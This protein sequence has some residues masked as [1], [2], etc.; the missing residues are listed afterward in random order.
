[1]GAYGPGFYGHGFPVGGVVGPVGIPAAWTIDQFTG[2]PVPLVPAFN[3]SMPYFGGVNPYFP[4]S[5]LA[6]T[7]VNMNIS[8]QPTVPST[9]AYTMTDPRVMELLAPQMPLNRFP[10]FADPPQVVPVPNGAAVPDENMIP[11]GVEIPDAPPV[12]QPDQG[13][14]LLNEFEAVPLSDK[15]SNLADRINSLRYQSSGDTAFRKED[16]VSAEAAYRSAIEVAPNRRSPY[17]R[18]AFVQIARENFPSAVSYLK[19]ALQLSD[20]ATRSWIS[21][22]ELYGERVAERARTHGSKLWNWLAERPLSSD[23]LLLSGTFQQLR[24]YDDAAEEL[25]SMASY[26][27]P[28]ATYVAQLKN[29]VANDIGQRAISHELDQMM[30]AAADEPKNNVRPTLKDASRSDEARRVSSSEA[31][32]NGGIFLRG[33]SSEIESPVTNS[34]ANEVPLLT[35]PQLQD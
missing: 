16:Y 32:R 33:A 13:T 2:Q 4:G 8:M 26:E 9:A 18:M 25:L 27:G 19:T 30:N 31:A 24:G 10:D 3:G 14:P 6:Q 23:R 20:D 28:E 29:I 5:I 22:E 7:I 12:P 15:V 35:I 17:L 11:G 21:A 34:D 1:M